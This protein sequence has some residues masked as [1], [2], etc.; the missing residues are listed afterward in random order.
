MSRNTRLLL[1]ASLVLNFFLLGAGAALL[2]SWHRFGLAGGWRAHA[3]EYLAP[4]HRQPFRAAIRETVR[5]SRP[6]VREGRLARADAAG[7][8]VQPQLDAAAVKTALARARN[9]DV[10]L[11][12][13]IE[14]K[15][16]DFAATLPLAER[17][18]LA[19]ALKRG[20]LRPP[21]GR[22]T[23]DGSSPPPR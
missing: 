12:G 7:L 19:E 20:P 13:R 10:T 17:Q 22:R 8:F 16:V 23:N 1:I 15:V 21:R 4:E 14:E 2:Y 9:A 6:L 11:R 5:D 3:A 18:A